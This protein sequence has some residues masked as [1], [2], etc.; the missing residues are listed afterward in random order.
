MRATQKKLL[1]FICQPSLAPD[2]ENVLIYFESCYF[3]SLS[4]SC[5]KVLIMRMCFCFQ[6]NQE[7]SI[8]SVLSAE[9]SAPLSVS[10]FLLFLLHT[11]L[12]TRT[13]LQFSCACLFLQRNIELYKHSLESSGFMYSIFTD[14]SRCV[15]SFN[16]QYLLPD[17][18]E[19]TLYTTNS[20]KKVTG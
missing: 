5:P 3:S 10:S 20:T 2:L 17:Q 9:F 6:D 13:Y 14:K 12:Q 16:A 4:F 19:P 11:E 7:S 1:P 18:Y 15:V 8:H